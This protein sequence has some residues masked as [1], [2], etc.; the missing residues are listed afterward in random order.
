MEEKR[1]KKRKINHN[2]IWILIAVVII[3]IIIV[4]STL[5][6][7]N[8]SEDVITGSTND[9]NETINSTTKEKVL[10]NPYKITNE[11]DGV[12]KFILKSDNGSGYTFTSEGVISFENG[13]CRAK[14]LWSSKSMSESTRIY[15]GFCGLNENDNS[16][17]YFLLNDSKILYKCNPVGK[18]F[19][20]EL[21]SE[22]D[23][24]SCSNKELSLVYVDKSRDMEEVFLQVLEEERIKKEAEELSRKEQ[25]ERE[26]KESCQTYTFEQMA[27]NPD[28]FK[29]TNVKLTGEV[30]QVIEGLY[31]NSFRVNITKEGTYSTYYTDTIYVNYVPGEGED[32]ILED[33]IITI[34]GTAQGDYSYTTTLGATVTLPFISAKYIMLEK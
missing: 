1:D 22:F 31:S 12:Y 33:D 6:D 17:F 3:F 25:E 26:F 23:L 29:G 28:N 30:V 19:S 18:D 11:Y 34:Y 8:N 15:D 9:N 13:I 27:R 5:G 7:S 10:T 14:Y 32:K 4:V 20:C 16:N 21:K 2:L 24:S